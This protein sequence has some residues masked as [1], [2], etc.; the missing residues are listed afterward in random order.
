MGWTDKTIDTKKL[1][2]NKEWV[3]EWDITANDYVWKE[4]DATP[5]SSI[6]PG[7]LPS[8]GSPK[9]LGKAPAMMRMPAPGKAVLPVDKR[10]ASAGNTVF[11]EAVDDEDIELLKQ[12]GLDKS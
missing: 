7:A 10:R 9:G 8:P 2:Q 3:K 4:K 11:K 6:Y 12:F 1:D 5:S